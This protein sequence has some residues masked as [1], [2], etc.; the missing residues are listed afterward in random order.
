MATLAKSAGA[1]SKE[2]SI[3]GGETQ[4]IKKEFNSKGFK[5]G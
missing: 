3:A 5:K 4:R 1:I 2:T